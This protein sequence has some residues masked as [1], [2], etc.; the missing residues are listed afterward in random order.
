MPPDLLTTSPRRLLMKGRKPKML[1]PLTLICRKTCK[2]DSA[3]YSQKK[4]N[5]SW[6]VRTGG[7]KK[8]EGR[9]E[10]RDYLVFGLF[11]EGP[12]WDY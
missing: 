2:V 1:P 11:G 4:R 5:R 6:S 10:N 3:S 9:E 7:V 12:D 8:G